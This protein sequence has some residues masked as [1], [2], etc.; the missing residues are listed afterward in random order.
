MGGWPEP[1][2][3]DW[4]QWERLLVVGEDPKTAADRV[5]FTISAFRRSDRRRHQ[6]ALALSKEARADEADQRLEQWVGLE[7]ASDTVKLYWHKY[8]AQRAGRVAEKVEVQ[9]ELGVGSDVAAAIDRFTAMV[10]AAAVRAAE[11]VGAGGAAGELEPGG[12]S[13]A[14]VPVG[15]V[16][17]E[18]GS[19]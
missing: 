15:R 1:D 16:A 7:D 4:E 14:R 8:Q 10:S 6:E 17:G 9:G 19:G 2:I 18:T 12:D 5:G 11:R 3:P 13:G